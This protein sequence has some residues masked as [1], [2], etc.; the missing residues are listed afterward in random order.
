[1]KRIARRRT[2]PKVPAKSK[3]SRIIKCGQEKTSS[4]GSLPTWGV[5]AEVRAIRP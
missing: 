2:T 3:T 5:V 1:L 4:F